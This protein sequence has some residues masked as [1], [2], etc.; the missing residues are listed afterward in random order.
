MSQ[1]STFTDTPLE[2]SIFS[3]VILHVILTSTA[4]FP[5]QFPSPEGNKGTI[6]SHNS[7][8]ASQE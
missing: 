2:N 4:S 5:F 1:V 3:G 6:Y 8:F 7:S